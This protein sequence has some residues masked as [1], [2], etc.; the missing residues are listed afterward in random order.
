V[1]VDAERLSIL[2]S[3]MGAF[4]NV[5]Y[6]Q[7]IRRHRSG[8]PLERRMVF[9]LVCT[10]A[11]F[12]IRSIYMANDGA[13]LH[14]LALFP[15]TL[16]PLAVTIFAEGLRRRHSPPLVK[17]IVA[18]GTVIA[19]VMNLI[20][21][22]DKRTFF[23]FFKWFS[24]LTLVWLSISLLFR[25]RA[26]LSPMENRLV[27]GITAAGA[28]GIVFAA[29]DFELRP[30]W[31]PYQL[32]GLGGLMFVYACVRLT[33]ARDRQITV[34]TDFLRTLLYAGLVTLIYALAIPS[35][36]PG[37]YLAV[38]VISLS[39]I[40]LFTIMTRIRGLRMRSYAG[41]SFFKWLS[42]VDTRSLDGFVESINALPAATRPLVLRGAD[43][44]AYD[45]DAI[46]GLFD[47]AHTIWTRSSLMETVAGGRSDLA[48]GADQLT[49]ILVTREMT[50]VALLSRRPLALLLLNMPDLTSA[51]GATTE[52]ALIQKY[53]RLLPA[54]ETSGV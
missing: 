35:A 41:A 18:L 17:V 37:V 46:A 23:A 12:V 38:Y 5:L 27:D 30:D 34:L 16:F 40:L 21:I 20:Y 25:R 33:N 51:Q 1:R 47:D 14:T 44:Q 8:S 50:H 39:F 32:G 19:V 24:V 7:Y 22:D 6:L 53:S 3:L 9:L 48:F 13:V 26:D 11:L 45:A 10:T 49:D 15:A 52:F 2:I 42:R 43:L 28:F 54:E 31:L 29:T 4:G 36:D